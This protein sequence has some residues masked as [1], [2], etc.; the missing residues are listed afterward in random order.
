M[1]HVS[2]S[3]IKSRPARLHYIAESEVFSGIILIFLYLTYADYNPIVYRN[4]CVVYSSVARQS[5]QRLP[6]ASVIQPGRSLTAH[7]SSVH[8][9]EIAST[10]S[11]TRSR[12]TTRRSSTPHQG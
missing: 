12:A 9:G 10:R 2:V 6:S 3:V 1:L 8:G 4:R 5:N 11:S 7:S